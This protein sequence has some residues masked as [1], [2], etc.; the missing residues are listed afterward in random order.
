MAK[1]RILALGE[2]GVGKSTVLNYLMIPANVKNRHWFAVGSEGPTTGRASDNER[3]IGHTLDGHKTEVTLLDTPGFDTWEGYEHV[4]NILQNTEING[5]LWVLECHRERP[6]VKE[7]NSSLLFAELKYVE[8]PVII[9]VNGRFGA[10]PKPWEDGAAQAQVDEESCLRYGKGAAAAAGL[11]RS[12]YTVIASRNENQISSL[13]DPII[14]HCSEVPLRSVQMR[15]LASIQK[16]HDVTVLAR[17]IARGIGVGSVAA[18]CAAAV[19]VTPPLT[20]LLC[21]SFTAGFLHHALKIDP[22]MPEIETGKLPRSLP[23]EQE[24]WEL[25]LPE[26]VPHGWSLDSLD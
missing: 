1:C 25:V 15:R 7:T 18:I 4:A 26:P 12:S 20:G 6:L 13:L 11:Q 21:A 3:T 5:V 9:L 14:R 8:P 23:R 24:Q 17:L 19:A 2:T 16:N 22:K 10:H